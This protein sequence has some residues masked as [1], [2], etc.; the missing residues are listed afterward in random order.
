MPLA[1]AKNTS[2][3]K[4]LPRIKGKSESLG[5]LRGRRDEP[6]C[7]RKAKNHRQSDYFA[8]SRYESAFSLSEAQVWGTYMTSE[9][10]ERRSFERG[11]RVVRCEDVPYKSDS[12]I[13]A[14]RILSGNN[15]F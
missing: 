8:D 13:E 6:F 4:S 15:V 10:R 5:N 12:V 7:R 9:R 1:G 14:R 3:Q 11:L 2:D